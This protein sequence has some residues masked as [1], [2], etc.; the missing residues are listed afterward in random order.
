MFILFTQCWFAFKSLH[1]RCYSQLKNVLLDRAIKC[2]FFPEVDSVNNRTFSVHYHLLF[3]C[4]RRKTNAK[5]A[6]WRGECY[7]NNRT[8]AHCSVLS[9]SAQLGN[10][11]FSLSISRPLWIKHPYLVNF[12]ACLRLK[13]SLAWL[14][15][16]SERFLSSALLVG[17]WLCWFVFPMTFSAWCYLLSWLAV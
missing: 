4:A 15:G 16:M 14:T 3:T 8:F 1:I 5:S 17:V 7:A 11:L 13:S 9:S 6:S 12:F 10:P 2:R